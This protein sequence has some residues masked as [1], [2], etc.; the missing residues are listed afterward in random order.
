M[1]PFSETRMLLREAA[2][3]IE[4]LNGDSRNRATE[5]A[6]LTCELSRLRADPRNSQPGAAA[7]IPV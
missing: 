5:I 7:A 2:V 4:R 1:V 6:R 3:A